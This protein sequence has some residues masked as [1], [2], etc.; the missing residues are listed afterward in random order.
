MPINEE[1]RESIKPE[2]ADIANTGRTRF[3]GSCTA[4]AFL[5]AFVDEGVKWAHMDIAGPAE[6]LRTPREG[7]DQTGFGA[8]LLIHLIK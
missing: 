3:G 1:H 2:A 4:A 8:Q 7:L 5:E 6:G